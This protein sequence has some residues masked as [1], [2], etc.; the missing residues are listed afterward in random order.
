MTV[1][2][3]RTGVPDGAGVPACE[4]VGG[5][6]RVAIEGGLV[7]GAA[8]GVPVVGSLV[9]AL[10]GALVGSI[11]VGTKVELVGSIVVGTKVELEHKVRPRPA[12]GA[13]LFS[14]ALESASN[15]PAK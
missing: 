7:G 10:T 3:A 6:V 12:A 9:G 15:T 4:A 13:P 1:Q 14:F 5:V 8:G 2:L 11:V